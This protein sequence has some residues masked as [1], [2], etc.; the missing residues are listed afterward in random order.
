VVTLAAV[1]SAASSGISS[2]SPSITAGSGD[3]Q[4]ASNSSCLSSLADQATCTLNIVF[5]PSAVGARSG[6]L[7][8]S[9]SAANSP[10]TL[11]LSGTGIKAVPILGLGTTSLAFGNQLLGTASKQY[12]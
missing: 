11:S 10:L 3:F 5:T 8:V 12:R 1:Y 7:T 4:I 6:T 9:S 2:I